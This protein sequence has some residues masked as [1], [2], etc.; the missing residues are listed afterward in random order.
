M[1]K[2][3]T[4]AQLFKEIERLHDILNATNKDNFTLE[5]DRDNLAKQIDEK[6]RE[7]REL[8]YKFRN[9]ERQLFETTSRFDGFKQAVKLILTTKTGE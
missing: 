7:I 2:K 8:Q 3:K 6:D 1:A 4:K 5:K 9:S